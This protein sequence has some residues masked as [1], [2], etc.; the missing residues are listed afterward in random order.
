MESPEF[1]G[2]ILIFHAFDIGDELDL[3]LVQKES[4][5][6]IQTVQL[7]R[8]FKNYHT[9][10]VV[11]LPSTSKSNFC[12]CAKIYS[13]GVVSLYYKI[14]FKKKLEDLRNEIESIDLH[15]EEQSVQDAHDIF[16]RI[17]RFTKQPKFY[18]LRSSY[19]VIQVSNCQVSPED[20]R[21][22]YG[23][24]IC[25][26]LRFET[27]TLSE[28]QKNEILESTTGYYRGDLLVIDLNA[29]FVADNDYEEL[30]DMFDFANIQCLELQ[31][32]DKALDTQLNTVYEQ[33]I[34]KLP[35]T[36]YLPFSSSY[37]SPIEQLSRTKVDISVIT[38]RLENSIK[39]TSD[40][41]YM[42]IYDLLV[43]KLDLSRWRESISTKLIILKDL[44]N[45]YNDKIEAIRSEIL[46][47]LIIILIFIELVI[48][49][50]N[51]I[52]R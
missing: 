20:L 9:P 47:V 10:L 12:V 38:E 36:T 29:A 19:D 32:F 5:L 48:G 50:L 24:I 40:A 45:I 14:P 13:F 51:Y 37:N 52:S 23:S 1:N 33:K 25:S 27:E 42:E 8:Y 21:K 4:G 16:K 17:K 18:H 15:Y 31:Y 11:N 28:F 39:L 2:N 26:L 7:P 49:L 3:N 34:G 35:W 46:S 41:Y 44:L 22:K 6:D 43:K 30:I